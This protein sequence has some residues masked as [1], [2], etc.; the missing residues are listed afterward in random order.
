MV[1]KEEKAPEPEVK[2]PEGK[3]DSA[4]AELDVLKTKL[5]DQE[6]ISQKW[7]TESKAHQAVV[8]KKSQELSQLKQRPART[9][10]P[11]KTM[12]E[13]MEEQSPGDPRVAELKRQ[14]D[15]EDALS[16]WNAKAEEARV[17]LTEKI[18]SKGGDPDDER[19]DGVWDSFDL[20][21]STHGQYEKAH[22]KADKILSRTKPVEKKEGEEDK[23]E[24]K[25]AEIARKY[26]E[27]K[28]Y[29]VTETGGPSASASNW[30]EVQEKFI[31]N[32]EDRQNT[33]RYYEMRRAQ[34]R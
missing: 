26:L 27:D 17:K 13:L 6:K 25:E 31:K 22:G 34:G 15:A 10:T 3:E 30:K 16:N 2:E 18:T 12:L 14:I 28:G 1:K 19:F 32:P 29:L 7:E 11:S 9:S 5:A 20:A 8:T 33:E 23:K 21:Y 4:Q 24:D